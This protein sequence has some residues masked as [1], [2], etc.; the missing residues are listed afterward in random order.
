MD[1]LI[2]KIKSL[3]ENSQIIEAQY[4]LQKNEGIGTQNPYLLNAWGLIARRLGCYEQAADYFNLALAQSPQYPEP[5]QNLK[6]L[7]TQSRILNELNKEKFIFIKSWGCGLWSDISHVLGQLLIAEITRRT[8]I[9]HW[10]GNSLYSLDS[11]KNAFNLYFEKISNKTIEDIQSENF[12]YWPPKWNSHNLLI[13][14]LYKWDG[15]FSRVSGLYFLSREEDVIVS[16]FWTPVFSILPWIPKKHSLNGLSIDEIFIYLINKYLKPKE[17]IQHKI[18]DYIINNLNNNGFIAAHIR[19]TDKVEEITSL[20]EIN[21]L[22]KSIIDQ[23]FLRNNNGYIFLMTD[24]DRILNE[25]KKYYGNKLKYTESIRSSDSTGV[26]KLQH[27]NKYQIGEEI[28]IDTYIASRAQVFI[29]NA[30]SNPALIISYLKKWDFDNIHLFGN[31]IYHNPGLFL[32]EANL[33]V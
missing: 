32:Y 1:A 7:I 2:E 19:G 5:E 20:D 9:V 21:S 28:I 30:T 18:N 27:T 6:K 24:D 14:D 13:D 17:E 26:H 4:L 22:Q 12:S 25:Y 3:I 11:A 16:D 31:N 10:G 33:E 23:E 8:P 29:G 15:P